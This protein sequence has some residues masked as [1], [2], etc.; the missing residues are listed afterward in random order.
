L[1][2]AAAI[3]EIQFWIGKGGGYELAE[4][5]LL[6]LQLATCERFIA[7]TRSAGPTRKRET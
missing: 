4:D 2:A 5:V 6:E 3:E 7:A 1:T